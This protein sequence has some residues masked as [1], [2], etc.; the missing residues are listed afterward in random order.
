MDNTTTNPDQLRFLY[1]VIVLLAVLLVG[2]IALIVWQQTAARNQS[3]SQSSSLSTT[4]IPT[5]TS[6]ATS[7]T[8]SS[9]SVSSVSATTSTT[10]SAAQ[11]TYKIYFADT[12]KAGA[13]TPAQML[14]SVTRKTSRADALTFALEQMIAGPTQSEKAAG[15]SSTFAGRISGTS[16]CGGANFVAQIQPG[17]V[18]QVKFCKQVSG[19]GSFADGVLL[20]SIGEAAFQFS[21]V[22]KVLILDQSG[23]CLFDESGLEICKDRGYTL[24]KTN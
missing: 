3:S 23:K 10:T 9:S 21:G 18:A 14:T 5:T 12:A 20:A 2:A 22:S 15:L 24:Q 16:N 17:Q 1:T 19:V 13:S 8:S 6:S 4:S 11:A 7:L